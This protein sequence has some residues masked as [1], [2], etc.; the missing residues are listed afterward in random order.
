MDFIVSDIAVFVLKRDVKLQLTHVDF[1]HMYAALSI[2]HH[3][4]D[5]H[6]VC[7]FRDTYISRAFICLTSS[8]CVYC[9]KILELAEP[10]ICCRLLWNL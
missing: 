9:S 2:I 5:I 3:E 8:K 6:I 10:F 1:I 4:L 7:N